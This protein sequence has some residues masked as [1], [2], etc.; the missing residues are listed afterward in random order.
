MVKKKGFS[1]YDERYVAN[2]MNPGSP[3][4]N[5]ANQKL[6]WIGNST[7]AWAVIEVDTTTA[8]QGVPKET[9]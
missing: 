9:K 8:L 6:G 1:F 2:A 7:G 3:D 5:F 4:P